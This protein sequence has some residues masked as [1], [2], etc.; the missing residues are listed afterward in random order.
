MESMKAK[1]HT[2]PIWKSMIHQSMMK[3]KNHTIPI[4]KSMIH[5]SMND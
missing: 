4:W 2:I 1:N 3:A 5:Q